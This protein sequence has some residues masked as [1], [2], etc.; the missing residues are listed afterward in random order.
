[1]FFSIRSAKRS[2][3]F[4]RSRGVWRDH[5][6]LSKE[7]RGRDSLIDVGFV[8][9]GNLRQFLACGRVQGRKR[10]AAFGAT[11]VAVDE[12]ARLEDRGDL[13]TDGHIVS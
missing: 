10:F 1:M 9:R 7:A 5:D 6:P 13:D 8:A 2:R 3:V 4:L 12:R 11:I